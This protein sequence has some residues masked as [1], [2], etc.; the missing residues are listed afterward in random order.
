MG[1]RKYKTRWDRDLQLA[2]MEKDHCHVLRDRALSDLAAAREEMRRAR[3]AE[4]AHLEAHFA[5]KEAGAFK[6]DAPWPPLGK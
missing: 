2:T 4:K 3:A 1:E 6:A 5:L